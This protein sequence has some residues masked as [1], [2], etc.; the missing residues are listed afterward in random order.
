VFLLG[1]AEI[2][3]RKAMPLSRFFHYKILFLGILFAGV[4]LISGAKSNKVDP[5]APPVAAVRVVTDEYFGVKVA[6]PYRYME[7]LANPESLAA[8]AKA[9]NLSETELIARFGP[10]V[11]RG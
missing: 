2:S 6:D 7:D 8:L 11:G 1:L 10:L 4:A 3:G 9:G 5:A